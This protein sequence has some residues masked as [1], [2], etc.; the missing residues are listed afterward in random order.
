MIIQYR[1]K[2][3]DSQMTFSVNLII[4]EILQSTTSSF[5]IFVFRFQ[6]TIDIF[7]NG[8]PTNVLL[9]DNDL[10][11]EMVVLAIIL[12]LGILATQTQKEHH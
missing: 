3:S 2:G 10:I 8:L 1:R 12:G 5:K 4:F 9:D 6:T 7:C 11:L